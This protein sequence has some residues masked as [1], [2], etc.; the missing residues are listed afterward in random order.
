[1]I[2]GLAYL[3]EQRSIHMVMVQQESEGRWWRRHPAVMLPEVLPRTSPAKKPDD[4]LPGCLLSMEGPVPHPVF[5][6]DGGV[7]PAL[8]TRG[9]RGVFE[10]LQ[11]R[12]RVR[13]LS[14]RFVFANRTFLTGR[15]GRLGLEN[16]VPLTVRPGFEQVCGAEED[17]QT[18]DT[19]VCS[20]VKRSG[21]S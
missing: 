15:A 16:D 10:K 2:Q 17:G 9:H 1:M 20:Q 6:K 8:R 4:I 14:A 21:I 13:Q 19:Q 12:L 18:G 3:P 11:D 7:D 5:D